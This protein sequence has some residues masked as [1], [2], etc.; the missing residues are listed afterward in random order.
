MHG[1]NEGQA[2]EL[3]GGPVD[4]AVVCLDESFRYIEIPSAKIRDVFY[5]YEIKGARAYYVP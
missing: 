1:E 5:L 2:I 4:G 3:I